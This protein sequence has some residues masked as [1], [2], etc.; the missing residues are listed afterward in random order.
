MCLILLVFL[1]FGMTAN[2]TTSRQMYLS[3]KIKNEDKSCTIT[4]CC[5]SGVVS[6]SSSL[7]DEITYMLFAVL[8]LWHQQMYRTLA[9]SKCFNLHS[10]NKNI[11]PICS[12]CSSSSSFRNLASVSMLKLSARKTSW[13]R[14]KSVNQCNKCNNF[15]RIWF[16]M[17]RY[18]KLKQKLDRIN[19]SFRYVPFSI[20]Q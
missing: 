19:I 14:N 13:Y 8:M 20:L 2:R 17:W 11:I 15:Y 4:T 5:A 10:K 3:F 1:I 12:C 16:Q 6:L 18:Q 9:T 7:N